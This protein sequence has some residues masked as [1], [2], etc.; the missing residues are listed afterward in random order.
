VN[1]LMKAKEELLQERDGHV[2]AIV[3]LR[4]EAADLQAPLPTSA[5]GLGLAAA[6]IC[7]GTGARCCPHLRRDRARPSLR[8]G[9]A[10]AAPTSAPGLDWAA[11]LQDKLTESETQRTQQGDEITSLREATASADLRATCSVVHV[12][13]TLAAQAI[14]LPFS[15][16][17]SVLARY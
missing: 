12:A 4:N 3:Q 17:P 5:P 15:D 11:H 10:L 1:E 14:R 9:T 2:A 6:H 7:A 13:R 16:T 8:A